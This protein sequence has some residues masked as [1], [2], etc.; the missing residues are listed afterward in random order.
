M[1]SSNTMTTEKKENKM[2]VMP[3]NK[4]LVSMS[5]PMIVSM[6]VQAMYNL[7]DSLFL[8]RIQDA[9]VDGSAGTA[10][11]N[12]LGMAFPIQTLLIAFG[13]GTGVG[14][15]A[16]LSRA[17][18]EKDFDTVN[19][20]A[21]NGILLSFIN[22][23]IFFIVGFFFSRVCMVIQGAEGIT[24][25][26]GVTYLTIVC[27]GSFGM[28]CQF[29]FE[30]LLQS[31]G[32]TVHTMIT[33][34]IGAIINIILDPILIFGLF[35]MPEMKVAGAAIATIIGQFVAAGLA[36]IFNLKFNHD[37]KIS[38]RGFY[39]DWRIIAKIYSVGLPSIIMQSIGAVMQSF[40]NKLL[41]QLDRDSISVFA[42]Y[43]KLQSLFFMPIF[44]L[45]NGMVPI[46]AFNAGARNRTRMMKVIKCT[47]GYAFVFMFLG[48]L[49]FELIPDKLLL[50]FD[51]GDDTLLRIGVPA[52]RIIGIHYLF[53]WFCIIGGSVFQALGNGVYSLI[54]SVARQLVV[55]V[56]AAYILASIGG[57]ALVWWCF[58]IA[59][60]MSLALTVFFLISIYRRI[61]SK[62]PKG[63]E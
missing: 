19:K 2:G 63:V 26:Y 30:R 17:L 42:V 8:A 10:A 47:M 54:V 61:I 53:A 45:N 25:E 32:R 33:Q 18:G 31:T 40:M 48:F 37:V 60:L 46:L 29:I 28:Y 13:V 57:L 1:E 12:A 55:L 9:S 34:S 4:L 39:P 27:C 59:E 56:P 41:V 3:I 38:F 52:L 49:G 35:G 14:V 58:P 22:Y 11:L 20:A 6:L 5:T 23:I 21:N 15:N 36:L 16:L 62:I 44:G 43:F 50:I 7:V 51:T 24:L